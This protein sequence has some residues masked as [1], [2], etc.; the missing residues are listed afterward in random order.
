[1][2]SQ[3]NNEEPKLYRY[4]FAPTQ[5]RIF[6]QAKEIADLAHKHEILNNEQGICH[7]V[8]FTEDQ[9][10][11]MASFYNVARNLLPPPG[12]YF[13]EGTLA[14]L[15]IQRKLEKEGYT[16]SNGK[17]P[18]EYVPKYIEIKKLIAD[19]FYHKAVEKYYEFLGNNDYGELHAE[20]IYLKRLGNIH[21][22]GRDLLF[23][24]PE[25]NRSDLVRSNISEYRH[26]IDKVIDEYKNKGLPLPLDILKKTSFTFTELDKPITIIFLND[27][28]IEKKEVPK[29]DWLYSQFIRTGR[30]F[31]KY[32]DQVK[33]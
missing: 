18:E 13:K 7:I 30:L 5:G 25:S 22:S 23:F 26:Y 29:V 24:R 28:N 33:S 8:T 14:R 19:H 3:I 12:E 32:I 10:D 20:L 31:D 16:S 4:Y 17:K 2:N 15:E 27:G 9:L 1:M 21:L 11:L 6:P